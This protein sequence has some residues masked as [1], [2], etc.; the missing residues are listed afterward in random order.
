MCYLELSTNIK[1]LISSK[2]NIQTIMNKNTVTTTDKRV[3]ILLTVLGTLFVGIGILGIF[4][5]ILPT[6][7]FLLLAAV[8]YARS[9]RRFY[10]RLL[11]NRW[12]GNYIRNYRERKGLPLKQKVVIII[13]LWVAIGLSATLAVQVLW[14]RIVMILVAIGVSIHILSLRTLK[15]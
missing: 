10:G 7:P 14:G 5:P 6:T 4:V 9:S 13:L 3:R 12:F 8:C 1:Y 2:F 11:N 15:Q